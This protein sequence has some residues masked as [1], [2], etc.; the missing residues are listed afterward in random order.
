M[1]Y[2]SNHISPLVHKF[3]ILDNIEHRKCNLCYCRQDNPFY[4]QMSI[5][6]KM[7]TCSYMVWFE[8]ET[9]ST[10]H[11]VMGNYR[12]FF[13]ISKKYCPQ[14]QCRPFLN[15]KHKRETAFLNAAEILF[16][17]CYRSII[18]CLKHVYDVVY[19]YTISI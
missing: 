3:I 18:I 13:D 11:N 17:I 19:Q 14:K 5:I 9:L 1:Q 16:F 6:N 4:I 7:P 8:F 15:F 12:V 2:K 10:A